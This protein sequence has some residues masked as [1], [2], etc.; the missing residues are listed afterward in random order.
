MSSPFT[1]SGPS[2]K[3]EKQLLLVAGILAL[4]VVIPLLFMLYGGSASAVIVQRNALRKEVAEL[5]KAVEKKTTIQKKLADYTNKSLP[6]S[7]TSTRDKYLKILFDLG[8]DCGFQDLKVDSISG[9]TASSSVRM[10]KSSG[11]QTFSFKLIGN[12][13]LENLTALLR[14]FYETDLLQMVRS[15][16]IKPIDQSNKMGIVME[17]E[18]IALD[19]AKRRSI[20]LNVDP[21][22][23]FVEALEQKAKLVNERSLFSVYRPPT[24]EKGPEGP[25]QPEQ[26]F[27]EAMYTFVSAVFEVNGVCQ[28]WI[29]RRLKGDKLKLKIGDRFEI[30]GVDCTIREIDLNQITISLMTEGEDDKMEETLMTVRVGKCFNDFEGSEDE[31]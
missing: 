24:P 31:T 5:E 10:G 2:T 8:L 14:R 15:L 26:Q 7:G 23:A 11:F 17:I 4:L 16:S 1:I 21:D 20:E 27:T 22:S 29:D 6:P 13:S 18:A 25:Q 28:V 3:R 9:S 12:A 19:S 30:D